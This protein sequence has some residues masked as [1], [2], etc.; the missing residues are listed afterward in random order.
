M[1]LQSFVARLPHQVHLPDDTLAQALDGYAFISN[2]CRQLGVHIFETRLMLQRTT[3]MLGAEAAQLFYDGEHVQREGAAGSRMQAILFSRGGVQSLDGQPHRTRKQLFVNLLGPLEVERLRDF[4]LAALRAARTRWTDRTILFD[5]LQELMARTACTWAGLALDE[6]RRIRDLTSGGRV[7]R[8]RIEWWVM[9]Q[10]E[11]VRTKR[12]PA[13]GALRAFADSDLDA[14]TAAGAVLDVVRPTIAVARYMTFCALALHEFPHAA[15]LVQNDSLVE[16][17]VQE[18]RRYY[19]FFP[20]VAGRVRRAFEL[21]GVHVAEGARV[22]LDLYGTNHDGHIWS[23]PEHFRPERFVG[24][25]GDP[26]T[27]IP[28]GGGDVATGHRCPGETLTIEMMKTFVRFV[29]KEISYDVPTQD[30]GVSLARVPTL[31]TSRF[32]IDNVR[33]R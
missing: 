32:V 22:M 28:Q 17:F 24:W 29:T 1:S 15:E 5:E 30:L 6:D 14:R 23:E 31:P 27:L 21:D 2:R 26:F 10:L 9:R 25:R 16:P 3:C 20:P 7:S 11:Q 4:V 33:P 18:V 12:M 13:T 8:A 19:P